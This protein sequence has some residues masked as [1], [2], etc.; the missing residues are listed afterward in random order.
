MPHEM[1]NLKKILVLYFVTPMAVVVAIYAVGFAFARIPTSLLLAGAALLI[2]GGSNMLFLGSPAVELKR[3]SPQIVLNERLK[4]REFASKRRSIWSSRAGRTLYWCGVVVLGIVGLA[5]IVLLAIALFRLWGRVYASTFFKRYNPALIAFILCI[6]F[7]AVL[8]PRIIG[9]LTWKRLSEVWL[10]I[11]SVSA[12][13]LGGLAF[14]KEAKLLDADI[15][16]FAISTGYANPQ[17]LFVSYLVALTF[18]V[19]A[20]TAAKVGRTLAQSD[21]VNTPWLV[22][23]TAF[24]LSW[25]ATVLMTTLLFDGLFLA[26]HY[27]RARS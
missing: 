3:I 18:I 15:I 14:I 23:L 16:G 22:F 2:F 19:V 12:I 7:Q 4:T 5:L 24:A 27:Y 21:E 25:A 10:T 1:S 20:I 13:S 11:P 9:A 17:W 6:G 8:R 26:F